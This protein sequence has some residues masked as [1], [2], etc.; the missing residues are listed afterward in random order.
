MSRLLSQASGAENP[1]YNAHNCVGRLIDTNMYEYG[2]L[3]IHLQT[4][5][6]VVQVTG[7]EENVAA[8]AALPNHIHESSTVLLHYTFFRNSLESCLVI[9]GLARSLKLPTIIGLWMLV[10]YR[11]TSSHAGDPWTDIEFSYKNRRDG[12]WIKC[13]LER[14]KAARLAFKGFASFDLIAQQACR[15]RRMV[16]DT[17]DRLVVS[18]DG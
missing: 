14:S 12:S 15:F 5:L 4:D 17:P 3:F 7:I 16:L 18:P 13:L 2:A 6:R 1:P 10:C 9:F 8:T 11:G